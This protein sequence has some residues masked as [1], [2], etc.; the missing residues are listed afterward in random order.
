MGLSMKVSLT[1]A[2]AAVTNKH[3]NLNGAAE[4]KFLSYLQNCLMWVKRSPGTCSL[5]WLSKDR[6]CFHLWLLH[7]KMVTIKGKEDFGN[8]MLVFNYLRPEVTKVLFS[9]DLDTGPQFNH[10][11]H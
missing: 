5:L 9:H 3:P 1:L 11:G 6:G 8:P 2:C 7:V 10:G 4:P